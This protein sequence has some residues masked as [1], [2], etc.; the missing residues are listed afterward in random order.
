MRWKEITNET[1]TAGASAAGGV[2]AVAQPLGGVQ[3]RTGVYTNH[4]V[5]GPDGRAWNTQGNKKKKKRKVNEAQEEHPLDVLRDEVEGTGATIDELG[6]MGFEE[7]WPNLRRAGIISSE[8]AEKYSSM[9]SKQLEQ[10]F[11]QHHGLS[12]K[13]IIKQK[14]REAEEHFKGLPKHTKQNIEMIAQ[15]MAAKPIDI[16]RKLEDFQYYPKSAKTV[17]IRDPDGHYPSV[18]FP[19]SEEDW[20]EARLVKRVPKPKRSRTGPMGGYD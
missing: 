4:T 20:L 6:M 14:D 9:N 2:A 15:K 13:D 10:A 1:A 17:V 11:Q 8:A 3:R 7:F 16:A 19:K 12:S 18:T 5:V